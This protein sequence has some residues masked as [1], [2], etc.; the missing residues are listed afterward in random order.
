MKVI[1]IVLSVFLITACGSTPSWEGMSQSE[2][3]QWKSLGAS[4][5][6]V[7]RYNKSGLTQTL[8]KAWH[9]AGI[10]DQLE[11]LDWHKLKFTPQSAKSWKDI[12]VNVEDVSAYTNADLSQPDVKSWQE[13]GFIAQQQILN[14]SKV[15]FTP[16]LAKSWVDLGFSLEQASAWASK[17][18]TAEEAKQWIDSGFAL[19]DA[20][21][22]RE[23]GLEPVQ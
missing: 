23:K 12:G 18:F 8:V 4:V 19:A 3:A 11:V 13:Y 6:E 2:I 15:G 14:W 17:K 9:E 5:E 22:N 16:E 1:A 10:K 7:D 21:M 20:V